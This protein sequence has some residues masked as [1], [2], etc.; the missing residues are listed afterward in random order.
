MTCSACGPLL[1][2]DDLHRHNLSCA[3]TGERSYCGR[4]IFPKPRRVLIDHA[5]ITIG[6]NARHTIGLTVVDAP[7]LFGR[8]R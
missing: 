6:A 4:V 7:A 8:A 3:A 1:T 5:E 2:R